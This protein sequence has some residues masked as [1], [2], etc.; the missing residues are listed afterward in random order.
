VPEWSNSETPPWP[1]P[2]ILQRNQMQG[3]AFLF[4]IPEKA[5]IERS[6]IEIRGRMKSQMNWHQR[7]MEHRPS[8][9]F[10]AADNRCDY[11]I[12]WLMFVSGIIGTSKKKKWRLITRKRS[13]VHSRS[14]RK[15]ISG[16]LKY[17]VR[18]PETSHCHSRPEWP[19]HQ[20]RT[21]SDKITWIVCFDQSRV[22]AKQA[23][24]GNSN[25]SCSLDRQLNTIRSRSQ[26][27]N[28][29][30]VSKSTGVAVDWNGVFG[31]ESNGHV[32]LIAGSSSKW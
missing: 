7:M 18:G 21:D 16:R 9:W 5:K 6:E 19:K 27:K 26:N 10:S 8:I 13:I 25:D 15:S 4:K 3:Q 12:G 32:Q 23:P 11:S 31:S 29:A 14:T 20:T 28:K 24:R 17:R 22:P 2:V 30:F 1:N